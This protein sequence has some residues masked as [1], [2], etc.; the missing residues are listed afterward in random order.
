MP[1]PAHINAHSRAPHLASVLAGGLL[2]VA[3]VTGFA[4][5]ITARAAHRERPAVVPPVRVAMVIFPGV[6]LG[7]DG[8]VLQTLSAAH[9]EHFP[10]DNTTHLDR[11]NFM[12]TDPGKPPMRILVASLQ[13]ARA[14]P[15]QWVP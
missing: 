1:D 15:F 3:L 13:V 2:T 12:A 9:L 11:P 10:D 4:T 8:K 6:R 14:T 7:P 5:H